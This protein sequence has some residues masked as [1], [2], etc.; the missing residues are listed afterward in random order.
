MRNPEFVKAAFSAIATRYVATNHV[1][2]MGIDLL[3][4]QRVV[5]LVS[6]WKPK[7]LLD[8]ATGTGDLALAL[9]RA[10]PEIDLTGS[11]FCQAMLDVA[12][13]RGLQKLICADAMN[14]PFADASYDVVTVAFG[15]RNMVDYSEALKEM[16]RVLKP[17]G[18][19]LILDFSLPDNLLKHPYRLY[20]HHILPMIAGLMT[21][22]RE[23][24]DYLADSIESFPSGVAMLNLLQECGYRHATHEPLSGGIASIYTVQR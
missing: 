1:L 23:A 4:R 3:W 10:M 18:H 16:K 21:G 5:Q 6:E 12:A 20:L 2:S 19:L 15:L 22:H 11:D 9:E 17:G 8:L 14:L 13:E 7:D 24:Y